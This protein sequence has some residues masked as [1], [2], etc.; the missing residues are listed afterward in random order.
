M[1]VKCYLTN[2][3]GLKN[4]GV[5]YV[6]DCPV[7]NYVFKSLSDLTWLIRE[8]VKKMNYSGQLFFE[9]NESIGTTHMLYRY[10]VIHGDKYIGIRVVSVQNTVTRVLF[11][12]PDH[13]LLPKID[14]A[15]YDVSR[16][17]IKSTV[18]VRSGRIPPG[19]YYVPNLVIYA[20][21]D[22]P[23]NID[24]SQWRIEIRGEVENEFELHLSDL[25]SLGLR[26]IKTS[27]HCVTGWS[28]DEV[29]FTGPL[30]RNI[31][32]RAKPRESV[33]WIYI[34][35]LDKYSTIIPIDEALSDDA[36]IAIEMNGKPL[37]IEHGYPARLVIPELYG[38]KSAKWVNKL[39]FTSE[40]RDGYW[41]ALGYHPR[42]RVEFEER[43]KKS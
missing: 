23:R 27:F 10:R 11:T 35:C 24:L 25:Y 40:Y 19:Q 43:F 9:S 26:T 13:D 21:L 32:N 33:E 30:L 39:V 16:D 34:E 36:I 2:N 6:I 42:G 4:K 41:E 8:F 28:V 31:I 5:E 14:I 15:K 22:I 20:I 38:W 12:I 1:V 18:K 37:E 29:E 17:L 3:T 7:S